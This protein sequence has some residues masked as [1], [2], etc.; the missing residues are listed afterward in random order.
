MVLK[1]AKLRVA[2]EIIVVNGA[3]T[4]RVTWIS[5]EVDPGP[6]FDTARKIRAILRGIL[7]DD[8]VPESE[9]GSV[10]DSTSQS[11]R[12]GVRVWGTRHITGDGGMIEGQGAAVVDPAA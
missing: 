4:S 2:G 9:L 8:G 1:I 10:E 11:G 12:E 5:D 6:V 7:R 3:K